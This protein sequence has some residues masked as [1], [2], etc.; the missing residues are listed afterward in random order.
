[1]VMVVKPFEALVSF[2]CFRMAECFK[3]SLQTDVYVTIRM[4]CSMGME[5]DIFRDMYLFM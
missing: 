3:Q 4:T 5:F 2:D 1:M